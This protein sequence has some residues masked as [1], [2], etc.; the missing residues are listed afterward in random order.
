MFLRTMNIEILARTL[1]P[2]VT[3][4]AVLTALPASIADSGS[5]DATPMLE[6]KIQALGQQLMSAA[7]GAAA[8]AEKAA[9]NQTAEATIDFLLPG[10]GA[11][12]P[13]WLRRTEFEWSLRED[14]KPDWS[15]LTVQPLYQSDSQSDTLFA[16]LSAARNHPFGE[17]RTTTN[18]GIG[19]RRLLLDDSVMVGAN[20]FLDHE[21]LRD[22]SRVGV[23]TEARWN[24]FDLYANYY[25][26]ISS[27]THEVHPNTSEKALDG[28]DAELASQVP[29]LP[30]ARLRAKYFYYD[31]SAGSDLDGWTAG[32]EVDVHQN[33]QLEFGI[34]DDDRSNEQWFLRVRLTPV[35]SSRPVLL[36]RNPLDTMAFRPRDMRQQTLTKVRRENEITVQRTITVTGTV[37][38]SRGT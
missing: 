17:G 19:Y 24:N 21:W 35:Q 14:N 12:A 8:G 32:I 22:H 3:S 30:S 7:A 33:L 36:S 38:I 16:Q 2:L 4:A 13:G 25:E 5:L 37:T 27:S 9:M 11:D 1:L 6:R 34:S 20:S 31:V 26:A 23:G 29:Y 18:L 10:V 15:I 28:F